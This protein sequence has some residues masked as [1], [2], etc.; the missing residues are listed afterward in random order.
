MKIDVSS[1][2]SK[3]NEP[4]FA[5][6]KKI[7]I[8][9]INEYIKAIKKI[10]DSCLKKDIYTLE[11]NETQS[12]I[13]LYF[14]TI[15]HSIKDEN[16]LQILDTLRHVFLSYASNG[17]HQLYTRQEN[18]G[19]YPKI[20]LT[21]I[22]FPNDIDSMDENLTLYRGCDISEFENMTFGQA[23]TIL[24]SIAKAFAYDYYFDQSWFNIRKRAV[25]ITNYSKEFVLFYEQS[26]EQEVVI[27]TS[28]LGLVKLM[29]DS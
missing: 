27:N 9:I 22:L 28:K 26:A 20:I 23:W 8:K 5:E 12:F 3:L 11:K 25:L 18:E 16:A 4:F 15:T 7:A 13:N 1:I 29:D 14:H 2:E 21:S 19:W 24:P 10:D 6:F 17:L